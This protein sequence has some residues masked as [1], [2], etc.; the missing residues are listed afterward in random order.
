VLR[1]AAATWAAAFGLLWAA[2]ILPRGARAGVLAAAITI[3]TLAE[4][5]QGP[6]INALVVGLAP[7]GTPGRH[8]SIFQLSWSVG[9]TIA[10]ALLLGLL[11]AGPRWLWATT[12]GLCLTVF[13]GIDH[14]TPPLAGTTTTTTPNR[15]R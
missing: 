8:L 7:A 10:P 3:F 15:E 9:Q 12:I 4:I 13:V 14:L 5:L 11:S 2:A 1:S 6:V